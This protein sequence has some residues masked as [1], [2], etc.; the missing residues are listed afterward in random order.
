MVDFQN[1]IKYTA[2]FETSLKEIKFISMTESEE[3]RLSHFT[4]NVEVHFASRKR[5]EILA[6]ARNILLEFD[7]F[8]SSVSICKYL[9]PCLFVDKLFHD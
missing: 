2:E 3:E 9:F 8:F 7:H 4:H 1:V 5:L 6:K